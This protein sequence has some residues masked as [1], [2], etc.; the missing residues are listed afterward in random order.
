[1]VLIFANTKAV[2]EP[3]FLPLKSV[4]MIV[5]KK[6]K[7]RTV[8]EMG[9]L[10]VSNDVNGN[11]RYVFHVFKL[12]NETDKSNRN[13]MPCN[14]SL[15]LYQRANEVGAKKYRSKSYGGGV[16]IQSHNLEKTTDFINKVRKESFDREINRLKNK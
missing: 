15:P 10:K 5:L 9:Y 7:P 6:F 12:E 3:F 4:K 2:N 1:M 16:V 8:A 14:W 13:G 11:P